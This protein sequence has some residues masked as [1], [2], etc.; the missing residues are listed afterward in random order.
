MPWSEIICMVIG[1]F[2]GFSCKVVIDKSK[3]SVK[4]IT[5]K[6]INTSGGDNAGGDINK[7]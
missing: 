7:S 1:F 6:K 2:T 4:K 3:K 5:Q